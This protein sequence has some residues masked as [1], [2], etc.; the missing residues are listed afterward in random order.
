MAHPLDLEL[1]AKPTDRTIALR[2]RQL[3]ALAVEDNG[4]AQGR[5]GGVVVADAEEA[6]HGEQAVAVAG[7]EV[8]AR[9]QVGLVGGGR[10]RA[11]HAV[12]VQLALVD[13]RPRRV[14]RR[15]VDLAHRQPRER[16]GAVL[17]LVFHEVE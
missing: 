1:L 9:V 6:G 7:E 14:V 10:H 15:H 5:N 3:I 4:V 8:R 2:H 17:S 11:Q 16:V 12:P 13:R